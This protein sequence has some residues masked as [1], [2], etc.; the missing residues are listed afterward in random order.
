MQNIK[1]PSYREPSLASIV[2]LT[3]IGAI[4][5]MLFGYLVLPFAAAIYAVLIFT[6]K[7]TKFLFS[8]LVPIFSVAMNF[9][10]NG[11]YSLEGISFVAVGFLIYY[12]Y[13]KN[14]SKNETVFWVTLL[15]LTLL[16]ITVE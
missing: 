8:Y 2:L 14:R 5:C 15:I 9:F 13:S 10:L 12:L 4:A 11:P 16:D 3:F 7:K 1:I 6:E